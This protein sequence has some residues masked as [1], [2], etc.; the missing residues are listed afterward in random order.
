MG[1][2]PTGMAAKKGHDA[3]AVF[4]IATLSV[5]FALMCVN[6]SIILV[7]GAVLLVMGI[8]IFSIKTEWLLYFLAVMKINLDAFKVFS[9]GFEEADM[10]WSLSL[11][12][13][14]TILLLLCALV[15]FIREGRSILPMPPGSKPYILFLAVCSISVLFSHDRMLGIRHYARYLSLFVLYLLG[16]AIL[17][18]KKRSRTLINAVL[19]S[20][21][22]PLCIGLYQAVAMTG[23]LSATPGFNRIFALEGHPNSYGAYCMIMFLFSLTVYFYLDRSALKYFSF[24][25]LIPLSFSLILTFSKGSWIG[26]AAAVAIFLAMSL[27]KFNTNNTILFALFMAA[28][29]LAISLFT[30]EL[31]KKLRHLIDAALVSLCWRIRLWR[32]HF[33]NFLAHPLTGNGLGTSS[34]MAK[35]YLGYPKAPH[36]DY[37]RLLAE[38]GIFGFAAY[39]MLL[40]SLLRFSILQYRK[41]IGTKKSIVAAGLTAVIVAIS[42]FQGA[43]NMLNRDSVFAYFWFFI[44]IAHA[45]LREEYEV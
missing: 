44:I 12:G 29:L 37:V 30:P 20:T 19:L 45:L 31:M 17:R 11:D 9:T 4:L 32:F 23:N 43:D 25:L 28:M 13:V 38:V 21:I 18:R 40:V 33:N 16:T 26:T 27:R 42:I 10:R 7:I 3:P 24:V 35:V 6:Y 14:V 15:Y 39:I 2:I 36:N 22:I 8:L 1:M 41:N 5:F 34:L